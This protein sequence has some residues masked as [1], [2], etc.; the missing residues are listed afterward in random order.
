MLVFGAAMVLMMIFRP[1]G[2]WPSPIR[3][4]ELRVA[5]STGSE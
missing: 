5:G 2:F 4:H 3:R 1:E